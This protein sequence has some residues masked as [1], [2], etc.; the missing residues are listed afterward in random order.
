ML[1]RIQ[2]PIDATCPSC[3]A[4]I[5]APDSLAGKIIKCPRCQERIVIPIPEPSAEPP[6]PPESPAPKADEA[7]PKAPEAKGVDNAPAAASAARGG[8]AQP[9][10]LRGLRISVLDGFRLGIGVALA[11]VLV[12]AVFVGAFWVASRFS[13]SVRKQWEVQVDG[14]V[15]STMGGDITMPN[16]PLPPLPPQI[17]SLKAGR[18]WHGCKRGAHIIVTTHSFL[19]N[20]QDLADIEQY[21]RAGQ[22]MNYARNILYVRADL[23]QSGAGGAEVEYKPGVTLKVLMNDGR[24]LESADLVKARKARGDQSPWQPLGNRLRSLELMFDEAAVQP[25]SSATFVAFMPEDMDV[26]KVQAI[27][28]HVSP[29]RRIKLEPYQR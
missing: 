4:P 16:D 13:K 27:Y 3:A 25:G 22:W 6:K 8:D 11:G 28:W 24:T 23:S 29:S 21:L 15:A 10:A 12:G 7:K 18:I 14:A 17:L 9:A 26:N 5:K 19:P 2:M 1:G 20:P